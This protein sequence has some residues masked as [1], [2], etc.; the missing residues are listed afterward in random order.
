MN[1]SKKIIIISIIS[2][3][4]GILIWFSVRI[5]IDSS[6][7]CLTNLICKE[8]KIQVNMPVKIAQSCGQ[9]CFNP[10]EKLIYKDLLLNPISGIIILS[11]ILF[12]II[13]YFNKLFTKKE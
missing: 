4:L 8:G 9:S 1:I 13:Y 7:V 2:L 10:I 11:L 12:I 3:I 5:V 6:N